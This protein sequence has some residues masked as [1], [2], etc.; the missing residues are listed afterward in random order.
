MQGAEPVR[1]VSP[2][3]DYVRVARRLWFPILLI[4]VVV[5]AATVAL[6]HTQEAR[7]RASAD[8]LLSYQSLA[9][10]LTG[11][12]AGSGISQDPERVAETRARIARTPAVADRALRAAGGQGGT[13]G[14]FLARSTVRADP[15]A[16]FL[17]FSVEDPQAAVAA[18]LATAYARA[19]TDFSRELDTAAIERARQGVAA[20]IRQLEERG[21]RRSDL[22]DSLVAKE[23]QLGELKALQTSNASVVRP[24]YGAERI[25]PRP[26]V[27]GVL[28]LALA[29][30]LAGCLVLVSEAFDTRVRTA[31]DAGEWLGLPLLG[32]LP[33]PP[34][35]LR[36]SN[37]LVMLAD[38]NGLHAELLRLFKT[39]FEGIV[40][41]KSVQAV[42]VTG[43][44]RHEGKSTIVA[45]LAV[46]L[47]HAG[48][49]VALVDLDLRQPA[50]HRFFDVS[51][52]WGLTDVVLGRMPLDDAIVSMALRGGA[53]HELDE[54]DEA[55][56]GDRTVGS[57]TLRGVSPPPERR[58][59]DTEGTLEILPAGQAAGDVSELVG[60]AAFS[61]L[62]EEL[63][64][65]ADLVLFDAPPVLQAN[66]ALALTRKV[67][68]VVVV[69][70]SNTSR[71]A[72]LAELG[73]VL[74]HCPAAKLGFVFA[75]A[76]VEEAYGAGAHYYRSSTS[77]R[78]EPVK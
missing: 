66:E 56:D 70:R 68:G 53:P 37:R 27:N 22:Y 57:A 35:R 49:R 52:E 17:V 30:V 5:P 24:A 41:A 76:T 6:S 32:R 43:A 1:D 14:D 51:R 29:V 31:E 73:R 46:A 19:F 60:T 21:D 15:K 16:D 48:R 26:L 18:R 47:A 36:R 11:I 65:R 50:L 34:S 62:L 40:F 4:L 10:S 8:V 58:N 59:R 72:T 44:V 77:A 45:N 28:A 9:A 61:A 78:R 7:Y 3:R 67:D 23:G 13:V 75:G 42:M 64:S 33:E 25:R 55:G 38:P 20:Q 12:S 69:V 71:R 63:R 74:D 54:D 39:N 2:P